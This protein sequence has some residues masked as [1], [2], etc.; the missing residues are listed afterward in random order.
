MEEL[1][2]SAPPVPCVREPSFATT[3]DVTPFA[4][5]VSSTF[6][7]LLY[8]DVWHCPPHSEE[9][10]PIWNGEPGTGAREP[11]FPIA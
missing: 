2:G 8:A 5:V 6:R 3:H 11:S 9:G 7:R 10:S 1:P 4:C